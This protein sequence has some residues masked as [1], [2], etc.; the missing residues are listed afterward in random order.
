MQEWYLGLEAH[1]QSTQM[2]VQEGQSSCESQSVLNAR[3]LQLGVLISSSEAILKAP[4]PQGVLCWRKKC[5]QGG[6]KASPKY[7]SAASYIFN[8]INSG[9]MMDKLGAELRRDKRFCGEPGGGEPHA[10]SHTQRAT[11]TEPMHPTHATTP[12]Y[13]TLCDSSRSTTGGL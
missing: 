11:R 6:G 2:I 8:I 10:T 3:Y 4:R 13:S 9:L 12:P 1:S 7:S 5:T